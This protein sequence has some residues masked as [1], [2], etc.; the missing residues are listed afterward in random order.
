MSDLK[1]IMDE[2][3]TNMSGTQET[4]PV[5]EENKTEPQDVVEENAV[6]Q[7]NEEPEIEIG[8]RKLKK[9]E[10]EQALRDNE[11][12]KNWKQSNTRKAQEL[13]EE[14]RLI[15]AEKE[16]LAAEKEEAIRVKTEADKYKAELERIKSSPLY[17]PDEADAELSVEERVR[18]TLE[19]ERRRQEQAEIAKENLRKLNEETAT[20]QSYV[21]GLQ[22][23]GDAFFQAKLDELRVLDPNFDP[24]RAKVD[25]VYYQENEVLKAMNEYLDIAYSQK[26][27]R[28]PK[29]AL[30][31]AYKSAVV[32]V[33]FAAIVFTMFAAFFE[34]FHSAILSTPS[35]CATADL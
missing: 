16:K 28:D 34:A 4:A 9:S 32:L 2:V 27:I 23:E 17:T 35:S 19:E 24:E 18:R 25:A 22:V 26:K 33:V 7:D 20:F 3:F 15:Q 31:Y 1:A 14:R 8:Q 13:A 21:N 29:S 5:N 6:N 11:N 10:I 12:D 30:E